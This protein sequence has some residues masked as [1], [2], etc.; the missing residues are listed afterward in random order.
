MQ[1]SLAQC[2]KL[3][4]NVVHVVSGPERRH[5]MPRLLSSL[6]IEQIQLVRR[7]V[8]LGSVVGDILRT[9]S[10]RE[11]VTASE[12]AVWNDL[13]SEDAELTRL[14]REHG[15]M[16]LERAYEVM[17]EFDLQGLV[18]GKPVNVYHVLGY[19]PQIGNTMFRSTC[20]RR[21]TTIATVTPCCRRLL[22]K[23]GPDIA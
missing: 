8:L 23:S 7:H 9:C 12:T 19:W 14:I 17:N 13:R 10:K 2:D 16:N 6:I 18:L 1:L 3:A 4:L 11:I 21:R 20:T 15:P 22:R 5:N